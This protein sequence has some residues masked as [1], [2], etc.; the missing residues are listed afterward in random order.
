MTPWVGGLSLGRVTTTNEHVVGTATSVVR[1]RT[2][3]RVIEE[4]TIQKSRLRGDG[5]DPL[6]TRQ[7]MTRQRERSC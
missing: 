3:K 1:A 2:V 7:P 6:E 4:E 5:V